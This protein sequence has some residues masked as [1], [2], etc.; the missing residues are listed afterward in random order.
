MN[1]SLGDKKSNWW[2]NVIQ[3]DRKISNLIV[4]I[5]NTALKKKTFFQH[6]NSNNTIF[7]AFLF[8]W[9]YI[10]LW[11][12]STNGMLSVSCSRSFSSQLINNSIFID[13][14]LN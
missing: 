14:F 4:M 1:Y 8:E 12:N 3:L 11:L 7:F 10:P 6:I 13:K 2:N 5:K 9:E